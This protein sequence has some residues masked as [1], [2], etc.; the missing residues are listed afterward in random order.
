MG[1]A[2]QLLLSTPGMSTSSP[3]YEELVR[4]DNEHLRINPLDNTD[5]NDPP[6]EVDDKMLLE[7]ELTDI[8][9]E[10]TAHLASLPN[11]PG[12]KATLKGPEV[13]TAQRKSGTFAKLSHIGREEFKP[14]EAY[15][16]KR[17]RLI[18]KLA[19]LQAADYSH[20][21][22]FIDDALTNLEGIQ[23]FMVYPNGDT[24]SKQLAAINL[25]FTALREA[26]KNRSKFD[27]YNDFGTF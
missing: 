15:M 20:V 7:A 6:F 21:E 5:P 26:E 12:L 9:Q 23:D 16:G 27:Q 11:D 3:E 14:F 17:G 2:E 1:R 18:L 22:M 8:A 13:L 10:F 19:P 4:Q 24:L 25:K